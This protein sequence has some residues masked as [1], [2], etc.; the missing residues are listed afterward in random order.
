MNDGS[1]EDLK[2]FLD[3]TIALNISDVRSDIKHLDN[4]LSADIQNLDT[5]LSS[6]IKNLDNKLSGKID[7]LSTSVATAIDN[8]NEATDTE[9]KDHG[10][11]ITVLEQKAA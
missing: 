3:K 2:Q 7:D 5:K 11:L 4:K 8:V 1:I 6:K 9:L 10:Q